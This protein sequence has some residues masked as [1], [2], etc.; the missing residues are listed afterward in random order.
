[1]NK[2]NKSYSCWDT[3]LNVRFNSSVSH[4]TLMRLFEMMENRG[5]KIRTDQRILEQFPILADDHFEGQRGDLKFKAEKYRSGFKFEFYQDVN[6]VNSN[7][8]QYDF[9]KFEK[10]PYLIKLQ[11]KVE[12]NHM[13]KLL[14]HEGYIDTTDPEF[15]T[16]YEKVMFRIKDC[17][18]YVEGKELPD[19]KIESYNAT[20]KDGKELRNG[21]VKYFRDHKGRLQR[22]TIYHNINNMWW[23]VIN[24]FSYRNIA[25]F[26]FFDLDTEENRKRKLIEPSGNH[27]PKSRMVP[28]ESQ[29]IDWRKQAKKSSRE[30]RINK[31]NEILS[32]LYSI[33]WT[34]R[35]F[36]FYLKSNGRAGLQETESKAFG[37]HKIFDE[38]RELTLYGRTLPMSSTESSWVKGL[39]EYVMHGKPGI[40][41]WF[42]TD[43]NGEGST[44]YKWPEV[45]EK[46]WEIGA[47]VS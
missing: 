2:T 12:R 39:R 22:G 7:G 11:F 21:Q 10:M 17:W 37:I 18:H 14:E 36:Q 44:A 41:Q 26:Y 8:G 40:T 43:R 13:K 27:N 23:V 4:P 16:A 6:T 34:S 29:I 31:A 25:S 47:L 20:D 15:K 35:K 3:N 42:C 30:E 28:N 32:Y 5:W 45:R 1:M 38:P 33:N 9:D 24:K 46:L 19:F